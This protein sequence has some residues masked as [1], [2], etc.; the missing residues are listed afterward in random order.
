MSS[1]IEKFLKALQNKVPKAFETLDPKVVEAYL[2]DKESG[3][4]CFGL[5]I[6]P[7]GRDNAMPAVDGSL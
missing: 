4:K 5:N 3:R 2:P 6:G 1:T 7:S